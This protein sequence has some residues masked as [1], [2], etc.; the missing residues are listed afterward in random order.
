ME[1]PYH[2]QDSVS[3]AHYSFCRDK[4][5]QQKYDESTLDASRMASCQERSGQVDQL[6]RSN[7][8]L[9]AISVALEN[10]PVGSKSEEIKDLNGE[11]VLRALS[12]VPDKEAD[13]KK[14]VDG[15][16]SDQH[17]TLMK[18]LYRALGKAQHCGAMLKWHGILIE[19]AGVGCIVRTM[20]DRKTV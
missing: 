8:Y 12:A 4:M 10:P 20:T 5:S 2:F 7:Q 3:F 9:E 19:A 14:V 16:N 11:I 17:D 6:V 18:Y 15:L 1:R 13:I